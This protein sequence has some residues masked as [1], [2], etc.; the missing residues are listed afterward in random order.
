MIRRPPRSTRTDTPFPYATL[1]RAGAGVAG[2]Q[3]IATARRLGAIVSAMDVRP[4]AREQVESLGATFVEV[5]S[6]EKHQA[7]TTA[8]YAR[9]MS[10]AYRQ[11]QAGKLHEHLQ[12]TDV[13][14]TTA[15]IPGRPAPA[16]IS[17]D[18]VADMKPRSVIV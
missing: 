2:L 12:R 5:D 14:V 17:A 9:E 13:V 11:R 18:M 7:E 10:A 1:F 6:D 16:L 15:L 4:A 3:A 8:G